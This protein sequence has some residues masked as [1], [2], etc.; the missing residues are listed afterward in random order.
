MYFYLRK[1]I[2]HSQSHKSS[3]DNDAFLHELK[4]SALMTKTEPTTKAEIVI[5]I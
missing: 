5:D 1:N 2:K 4:T 3:L